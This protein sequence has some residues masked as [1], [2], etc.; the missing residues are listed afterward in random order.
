M[1]KYRAYNNRNLG[2]YHLRIEA[3]SDEEA[4][5]ILARRATERFPSGV[6]PK[7]QLIRIDAPAK[8]EQTS[9]IPIPDGLLG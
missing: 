7:F 6:K 1:T 4:L 2:P 9:E 5:K 8:K 3:D